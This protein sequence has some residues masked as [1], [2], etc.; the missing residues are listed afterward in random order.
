MSLTKRVSKLE[1]QLQ[2]GKELELEIEA[3]LIEL[4]SLCDSEEEFEQHLAE[5][6]AEIIARRSRG[7][8]DP[9]PNSSR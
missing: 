1:A 7:A 8:P 5:C 9:V 4:R 6:E 2:T 3:L